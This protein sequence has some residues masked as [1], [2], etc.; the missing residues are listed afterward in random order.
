MEKEAFLQK[1]YHEMTMMTFR[2]V[3]LKKAKKPTCPRL[4][5][6]LEKFRNPDVVGMFQVS[7]S[8]KIAPIISLGD[9]D[10]DIYNIITTIQKQ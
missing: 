4:R 2:R 10:I 7:I 5:F 9:E 1:S 3:R 8:G 6:N